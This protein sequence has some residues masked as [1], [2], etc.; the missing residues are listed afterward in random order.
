V[1]AALWGPCTGSREDVMYHRDLFP[2]GNV[3]ASANGQKRGGAT[4]PIVSPSGLLMR[5]I[6]GKST[7][8]DMMHIEVRNMFVA[9]AA[10]LIVVVA[11]SLMGGVY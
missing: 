1:P 2:P 7:K 10:L 8:D 4:W 9:A 6:K 5:K 11:A 3:R